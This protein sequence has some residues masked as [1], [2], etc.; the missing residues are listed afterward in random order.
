MN[1]SFVS[2]VC[3]EHDAISNS[4][5]EEIQWLT[6]A[7]YHVRL[8]TY[9][10]DYK[11]LPYKQVGGLADVMYDPHYRHSDLIVWHFGVH[12]PLF[13]LLFIAPTRAK[14]V[15]VFH[16]ITPKQFVPESAHADID[17]SFSQMSNIAVA[18]QVVCDSDVNKEVLSAAG[19]DI[20]SITLPLA[21]RN[22]LQAPVAK[23]SFSDNVSR[24]A[25]VGRFVRSKGVIELLEAIRRVMADD[26]QAKIQL[27]LVGNLDFSD[28]VVL[29]ALQSLMQRLRQDFHGRLA[30]TL[31]GNA[32]ESEKQAVLAD[33]DLFVLPTYHE[34]FCVPILEALA[35]GCRVVAY[36][37]SNVPFISGELAD[38]V[39]TGD[40]GVLAK[41]MRDVLSQIGEPAWTNGSKYRT[42]IDQAGRHV[43]RFHPK[44]IE[45]DFLRFVDSMV[46]PLD[47][48]ERL[49]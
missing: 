2:G 4:I 24:I 25:F 1:V 13:N 15:V 30:I 48:R 29:D 18:D 33:A 38:L 12:Y 8:F 36:D 41:T 22:N 28:P 26:A 47:T 5:R 49:I 9:R 11:D 10:C 31:R 21:I 35:S 20:P 37:N 39:P 17:L 7:G 3:V 42:F 46:R 44:T 23:P 27:D 34:G 45:A 19:I 40:I 6:K 43:A 16:N 32:K 14:K